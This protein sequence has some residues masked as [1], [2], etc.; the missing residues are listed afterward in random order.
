MSS[1]CLRNKEKPATPPHRW[2]SLLDCRQRAGGRSH[3]YDVQGVG[4]PWKHHGCELL[5]PFP[6][7]FEQLNFLKSVSLGK[8]W[9]HSILKSGVEWVRLFLPGNGFSR[10]SRESSG[11]FLDQ[12]GGEGIMASCRWAWPQGLWEPALLEMGKAR[13]WEAWG[14]LSKGVGVGRVSRCRLEFSPCSGGLSPL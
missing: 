7:T 2:C 1:S 4:D 3:R 9:S 14:Q 6:G 11:S 10:R 8:S 12:S 13:R 5:V